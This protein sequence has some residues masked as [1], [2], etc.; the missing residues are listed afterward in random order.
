MRLPIQAGH[1]DQHEIIFNMNVTKGHFSGPS[2]PCEGVPF[3]GPG[4]LPQ[5][6]HNP[7]SSP[8]FCAAAR[9]AVSFL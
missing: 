3:T 9:A 1:V 8:A 2:G 5:V 6:V 4:D 7:L